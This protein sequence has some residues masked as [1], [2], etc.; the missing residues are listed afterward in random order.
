MIK[1]DEMRINTAGVTWNV[2]NRVSTRFWSDQW[3]KG[4]DPLMMYA[5]KLL[6]EVAL[7]E[8]IT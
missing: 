2:G 8:Y 6:L 5:M 7:K 1:K 3:V 4:L